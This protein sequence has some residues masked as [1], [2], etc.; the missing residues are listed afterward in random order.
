MPRPI[1]VLI[2]AGATREYLDPVRFLSN[3]SSGLMGYLIAETAKNNKTAVTLISGPGNLPPPPGVKIV[4]VVSALEMFKKAVGLFPKTDIF[5]A[6]AAVSDFRPAKI[7]KRKIRKSRGPAVLKLLPNPDI[8]HEFG[9]RAGK[10]GSG[11]SVLAGFALESGNILKNAILK[12]RRKN[13]DLIAANPPGSISSGNT[14]G[15]II[16]RDGTVHRIKKM[17]KKRFARILWGM[18]KE[19]YAKKTDPRRIK[20][21]GETA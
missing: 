21:R 17:N 1:S 9:M 18:I 5:I 10:S 4:R 15:F 8:L 7:S 19:T 3:A 12:L 13:L 6:A 2:T 20:A 14:S 11:P 16:E